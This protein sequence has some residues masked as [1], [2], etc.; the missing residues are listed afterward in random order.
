MPV[1]PA[2]L[3]AARSACSIHTAKAITVCTVITSFTTTYAVQIGATT[4]GTISPS[5]NISVTAGK[6]QVFNLQL[7][8]GYGFSLVSG[9]VETHSVIHEPNPI[10]FTF[11]PITANCAVIA[12]FVP[13]SL[14][15][16]VIHFVSFSGNDTGGSITPSYTIAVVSGTAVGFAAVHNPGYSA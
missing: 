14:P 2:V 1:Q 12:T 7:S 3:A 10:S 16:S 4:G 5:G 8:P 15:T 13:M 9:C 6:T 11:G